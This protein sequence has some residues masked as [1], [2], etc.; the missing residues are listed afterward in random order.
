MNIWTAVEVRQT[1]L[2][3]RVSTAQLASIRQ[4]KHVSD[5]R[6]IRPRQFIWNIVIPSSFGNTTLSELNAHS[7]PALTTPVKMIK[8]F[9]FQVCIYQASQKWTT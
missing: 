1:E 9:Q 7:T 4:R 6:K 8:S 5:E 3:R 2:R